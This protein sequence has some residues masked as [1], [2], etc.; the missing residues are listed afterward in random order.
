MRN[1]GSTGALVMLLP[2]LALACP[3]CF[4]A[5]NEHVLRTYYLTA[6]FMTLLPLVMVGV[7]AAWLRQRFKRSG[8]CEEQP[9]LGRG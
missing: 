9:P 6:L 7:L 2:R 1:A 3:I 4:S 8:R 5:A